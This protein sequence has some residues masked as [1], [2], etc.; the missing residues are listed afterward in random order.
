M[1]YIGPA[2]EAADAPYVD[3]N[4]STGIRGSIVPAK[5]I[6]QPLRELAHLIA[7]AGLTPDDGNLEQVREAIE[8]LIDAA[9]GAGA[10]G[11][12][13]TMAQLRSRMPIYPDILTADGKMA[14][15]STGPGN[16]RVSAGTTFRHRGAFPITTVQTDLVPSAS[17]TYHL[18]CALA[19]TGDGTFALKDLADGAYNP[20][21]LAETH[22]GFD[23]TYDDM[24]VAKV[25][26]NAGNVPTITPLVNRAS[27]AAEMSAEGTPTVFTYGTGSDGLKFSN[28][29]S[30]DWSRTPRKHL[31]GHVRQ[32]GNAVFQGVANRIDELSPTSRYGIHAEIHSDFDRVISGVVIG[33]RINLLAIG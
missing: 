2:G 31:S 24:L 22:A 6:E 15:T 27:L 12:Y 5:A 16:V 33:A 32:S 10:S 3:G 21:A 8:A 14:L 9:V 29:F 17:K 19:T 7:F 18:R 13:V 28:L 1:K 20:G 11:T 4:R 26:T 30:L 25:V 23:S